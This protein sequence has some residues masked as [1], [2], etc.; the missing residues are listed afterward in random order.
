MTKELVLLQ[1]KLSIKREWRNDV[2][3]IPRT[4][5]SVRLCLECPLNLQAI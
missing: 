4:V 3:T 2:E 1:G 5:W